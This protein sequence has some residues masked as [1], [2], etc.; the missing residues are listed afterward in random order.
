MFDGETRKHIH[1]RDPT[2]FSNAD[3]VAI[4]NS[5]VPLLTITP[6]FFVKRPCDRTISCIRRS[7]SGSCASSQSLPLW[8]PLSSARENLGFPKVLVT[9]LVRGFIPPPLPPT[10]ETF[11]GASRNANAFARCPMWR[12]RIW[13]MCFSLDGCVAYA[14]ICER[15]ALR[16]ASAF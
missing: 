12:C 8:L 16:A 11:F 4:W 13:N 15:K 10:P 1:V 14:L 2:S 6:P 3:P 5:E 7:A 9:T